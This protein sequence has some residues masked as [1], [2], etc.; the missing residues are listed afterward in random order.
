[1]C[2]IFAFLTK[3]S[4][5]K[6]AADVT[7]GAKGSP[8]AFQ[9]FLEAAFVAGQ[10]RGPEASASVTS[11]CGSTHA[12]QRYAKCVGDGSTSPRYDPESVYWYAGFHRLAI[13]GLTPAGM[14]PFVKD[15]VVLMCNGEIYNY[16][17]LYNDIK[18]FGGTGGSG[19]G[20]ASA[21]TCRSDCEVI[22]DYYLKY[23]IEYTVSK[24]KGVF[25]FVII[26]TRPDVGDAGGK[27]YVVR[28]RVG[29]R[30]LYWAHAD[31]LAGHRQFPDYG[32]TYAIASEM[33]QLTALSSRDGDNPV[34]TKSMPLLIEQFPAG[35]IA[36]I[37]LLTGEHELLR[38]WSAAEHVAYGSCSSVTSRDAETQDYKAHLV[39]T[40]YNAVKMRVDASERE[41][42]CLLSGGLDSSLIASMVSRVLRERG[43]R[44]KTFS[45]GMPGSEDLRCARLVAD[46]IE[47]DHT[48]IVTTTQEMFDAIPEVVK[49][50]ESYDTTTVRASVGN[51]LVCKHI[52]A[53]CD[54][55]VV[56]NGDG[57]D[58]VMG[59]YLYFQVIGDYNTHEK[60]RLRLLDEIAMYDVL[61]SDKS[62]AGNGLEAR[63]PFLDPQFI[64]TY[65][66]SARRHYDDTGRMPLMEKELLRNAVAGYRKRR[67]SHS[68]AGGGSGD[69]CGYT[70]LPD[71][72]L[73]RR[74]EAFSD[75]VSGDAKS[76]KDEIADR[77]EAAG[78]PHLEGVV[79]FVLQSEGKMTTE[80]AWYKHLFSSALFSPYGLWFNDLEP[81]F[82]QRMETRWMP[83]FVKAADPSARSLAIY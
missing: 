53:N 12:S 55:K 52:K 39:E 30:S 50:I 78:T 44:V 32:R 11:L 67:G 48:E 81:K 56:F 66:H 1:M 18:A 3:N 10:N 62:I 8:T 46:F 14:Q 63:T 21:N 51:Y 2:G 59:G 6:S 73:F 36:T 74:K 61:R 58:E 69:E 26:D 75:G 82:Y 79:G 22:L 72:V 76:W 23:G 45:I 15:G 5:I 24:L 19:R 20:S 57:A 64:Q 25:A 33:K 49:A 60:E 28:D 77:M 43:Q 47:S 13:N 68:G 80:Q 34:Y 38:Y 37:D 7:A 71:E 83:R 42:C 65:F 9:R 41:V 29:I 35:H 70:Y 17:E 27:M 16:K 4:G 40:L 54:A 31:A